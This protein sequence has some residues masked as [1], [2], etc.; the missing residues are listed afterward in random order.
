MSHA[1]MDETERA[2]LAFLAPSR[3]EVE[4]YDIS[5][6]GLGVAKGEVHLEI[7]VIGE[8]RLVTSNYRLGG[9]S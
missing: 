2:H 9:L 4:H 6:D 3:A 7:P 8:P 5:S 1:S